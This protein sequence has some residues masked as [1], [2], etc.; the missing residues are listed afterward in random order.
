MEKRL[1][2]A[3]KLRNRT[4]LSPIHKEIPTLQEL[5][6][7][8]RIRNEPIGREKRL[9]AT[10]TFLPM[11]QLDI[12]HLGSLPLRFI[13]EER[14]P[15]NG[16]VLRPISDPRIVLER[17]FCVFGDIFKVRAYGSAELPDDGP[18]CSVDFEDRGDVSA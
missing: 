3:T 17:E 10:N 11:I 9:N 1:A 2:L 4:G 5:R 12:P 15:L 7:P 14:D 18:I 6:I 13:I 16:S 8:L